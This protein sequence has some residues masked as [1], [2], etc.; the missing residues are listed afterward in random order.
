MQP[1]TRERS[2]V[3]RDFAKKRSLVIYS[4][5]ICPDWLITDTPYG[6]ENRTVRAN[7]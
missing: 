3:T 6:K 7:V 4:I 5:P 2:N 1:D